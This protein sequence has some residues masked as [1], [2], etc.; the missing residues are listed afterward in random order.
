MIWGE[1][2]QETRLRSDWGLSGGFISSRLSKKGFTEKVIS[3]QSSEEM[4]EDACGRLGERVT[5]SHGSMTDSSGPQHGVILS[6]RNH[7]AMSE[8]VCGFP[9]LGEGCCSHVVAEDRVAAKYPAV[10]RTAPVTK[11]HLVQSVSSA[12]VEKP[13]LLQGACSAVSLGEPWRR[14]AKRQKGR[15]G[16]GG[17]CQIVPGLSACP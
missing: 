8:G 3:E 2:K 6:F 5:G 16:A 4:T 7:S 10:H 13:G 9:L 17:P 1:I 15:P 14:W 12:E 11:N